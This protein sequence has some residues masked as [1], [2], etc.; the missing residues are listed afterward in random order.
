[1][2]DEKVDAWMPLWIGSYL[3]DTMA[4]SRDSHGGYL[5]LLFAYWRNKGPLPDDDD[6]LAGITKATP[7]EWKKLRPRLA[8]FFDIADGYWS[9]GRA[10]KELKKA[11]MLKAA[12]VSKARAGA[13]AR[14]GKHRKQSSED[15]AGDGQSSAAGNAPSMPGALPEQSPT[16]SPTPLPLGGSVPIGTDGGQPPAPPE[17][18]K[19]PGPAPAPAFTRTPDEQS[20]A[21]TWRA[22]VEV[23]QAGGCKNEATCRTFMGKLVQDYT[24]PVVQQAVSAAVTVQPADA[25]E[26]LKATCQ[27]LKGERRDPVTVPSDAAE[28][29]AAEQAEADRRYREAKANED[30]AQVAAVRARLAEA[31]QALKGAGAVNTIKAAA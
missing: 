23:L 27:R 9:H 24:F 1:M 26:Y 3:A 2:S 29:T 19:Q 31:T 28:R 18:G 16:P 11:G 4:L 14:W 10:D 21:D 20:K 25:R 7:A 8:R 13:E 15:A 6:D 17:A 12:A 30:P 5:L 22:A